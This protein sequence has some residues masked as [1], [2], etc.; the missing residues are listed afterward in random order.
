MKQYGDAGNTILSIDE[1]IDTDTSC[2]DILSYDNQFYLS[3]KDGVKLDLFEQLIKD[4]VLRMLRQKRLKKTHACIFLHSHGIDEYFPKKTAHQISMIYKTITANKV[5]TIR[6]RV[7]QKVLK[8]V[9][10]DGGK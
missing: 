10:N 6:F 9:L 8:E 2:S 5:R 7:A 4:A 1:Q 3:D